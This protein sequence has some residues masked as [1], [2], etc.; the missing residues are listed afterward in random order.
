MRVE[1][2][3]QPQIDF[4]AMRQ[5]LVEFLFP[6]HRTQ[7]GLRELRGLVHII[8][9]F[10]HSAPRINYTQENYGIDLERD[11]VTGDD[12]LRGNLQCLLPQ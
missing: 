9:D 11:I 7:R 12:V 1:D 5:Q 10:D 4:L 6:E 8:R 3:L 2:T